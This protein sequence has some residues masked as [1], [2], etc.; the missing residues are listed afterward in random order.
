MSIFNLDIDIESAHKF[1]EGYYQILF[2]LSMHE[3]FG[4]NDLDE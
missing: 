1:S 4:C 2:V 3:K